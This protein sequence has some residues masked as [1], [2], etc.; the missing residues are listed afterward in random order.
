MTR[1][2]GMDCPSSDKISR[3]ERYKTVWNRNARVDDTRQLLFSHFYV[4]CTILL[5]HTS[6]GLKYI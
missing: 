6:D 5:V 4:P 1:E 3:N 2:S